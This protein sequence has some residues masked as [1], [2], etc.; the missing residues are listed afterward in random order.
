MSH[1]QSARLS[2]YIYCI[3]L[4]QPEVC[5]ESCHEGNSNAILSLMRNIGKD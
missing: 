5:S 1:V 4:E 3:H 2:Y